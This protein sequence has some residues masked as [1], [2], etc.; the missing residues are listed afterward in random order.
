MIQTSISGDG[1]TAWVADGEHGLVA[2]DVDDPTAPFVVGQ[3]DLEGQ[4]KDLELHDGRAWVALGTGGLAVVDLSERTAPVLLD[5]ADTRRGARAAH[6][7]YGNKVAV[8][9]GDFL[10]A[11]AS[12]ALARLGDARVVGLIARSIEEAVQGELMQAKARA[13]ELLR[14]DHYLERAHR[15]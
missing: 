15:R 9:A 11:K 6:R 4:A 10:L 8:L 13:A 1:T 12:V 5:V 3:V 2:V 14:L 7:L